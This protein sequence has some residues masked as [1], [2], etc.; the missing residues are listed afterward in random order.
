MGAGGAG[1]AGRAGRAGWAGALRGALC[2]ADWA[3]AALLLG[4][5]VLAEV[6][7]ARR[8]FLRP[9]D[10]P[11][12]SFPLQAN[13]V[14]SW[15]VPAANLAVPLAV[16]AA[17][18]ALC[19]PPP[20]PWRVFRRAVTGLL[21]ATLV[22]GALTGAVKNMV[23]RPRPDM[24]SRCFPAGVPD[25]V[26]FAAPGVPACEHDDPEGWKSF[27]SGHSSWYFCGMG[28]TSLYLAAFADVLG[29]GGGGAGAL[30]RRADRE[31]RPRLR[32]AARRGVPRDGL[33][34][35]PFRR[36]GREPPGSPL[37]LGLLQAAGRRAPC[38]GAR[39]RPP[40]RGRRGLGGGGGGG[41][42]GR[43]PPRAEPALGR[44]VNGPTPPWLAAPAALTVCA[45]RW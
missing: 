20:G 19:R 32:R 39:S 30:P 28:Y 35:Q 40:T 6:A 8:R 11:A 13:T 24:L 26:P 29:G 37:R 16:M 21:F 18:A 9:A 44:S 36:A 31:P 45:L 3:A 43:R 10:L 33:P 27:P 42:G 4:L 12:V 2:A 41:G 38:P 17:H 23:G 34:P 5:V 22:N 1:G 7:P 15:S 14:P 25:P